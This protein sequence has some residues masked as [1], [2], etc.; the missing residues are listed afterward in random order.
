MQKWLTKLLGFS[1]EIQYRARKENV[2]ADALS[3]KGETYGEC[4]VVIQVIPAWV[5]GKAAEKENDE[6]QCQLGFDKKIKEVGGKGVEKDDLGQEESDG[7]GKKSLL[8]MRV[9]DGDVGE[10]KP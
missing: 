3:R 5:Q 4:S 10:K 7:G 9:R 2:V 8:H 1:Y 6:M